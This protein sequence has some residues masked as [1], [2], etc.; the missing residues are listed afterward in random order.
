M[1]KIHYSYDELR[2]DILV[3]IRNLEH[4]WWRPELILGIARGGLIPANYL[5]QWYDIPMFVYH[6]SLRDHKRIDAFDGTLAGAVMN[7]NVLIVDDICDSGKTMQAIELQIEHVDCS[8]KFA[9]LHYNIGQD[10]FEPHFY[11][12]E[13]NK[14]EDPIWIVYPWEEWWTF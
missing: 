6:Y 4:A 8:P 10:T 7:K 13:I 11:S 14:K 1:N 2:Q 12:K 5:S 3:I 9:C